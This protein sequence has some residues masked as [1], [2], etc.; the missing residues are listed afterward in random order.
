MRGEDLNHNAAAATGGGNIM[1]ENTAAANSGEL[2]L[3]PE[4]EY[5][6]QNRRILRRARQIATAS[7]LNASSPS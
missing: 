6:Q 4:A 2:R 3:V 7:T 1:S 5:F